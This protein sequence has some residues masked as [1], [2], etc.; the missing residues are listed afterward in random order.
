MRCSP[1]PDRT[2]PPLSR[3]PPHPRV[4]GL[5]LSLLLAAGCG[6]P[7][8]VVIVEAPI[9]AQELAVRLEANE[10][11]RTPTRVVF[12]WEMSEQG[13]RVDGRG[14]ARLEPPYKG[15][16]DL[17][18]GNGEPA[19]S[20]SVIDDDLRLPTGLPPSVLPPANLLWG[21]LGVFRPGLGTALLG[22]ERTDQ[23]LQLRYGL[24]GGDEAVYSLREGR[25]E[26]VDVTRR[27]S[28][29]QTLTLQRDSLQIPVEALYRDLVEVRELRLKRQTVQQTEPFPAD[30]WRP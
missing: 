5:A 19:G 24:P 9:N 6:G 30:I 7:G 21:A 2:T 15:R 3:V 26:R 1:R 4:V 22:A 10:R 8:R 29:I 17:F 11:L 13:V 28:V 20:A 23:H 12:G 25:I 16:L 14:S 18:L 27:G